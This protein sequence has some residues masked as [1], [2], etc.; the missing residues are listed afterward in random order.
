MTI[1]RYR[2]AQ[3][4]GFSPVL[5]RPLYTKYPYKSSFTYGIALLSKTLMLADKKLN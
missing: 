4:E 5:F 2:K 1:F 3:F